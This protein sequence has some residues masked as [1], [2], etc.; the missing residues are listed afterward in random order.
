VNDSSASKNNELQSC[1][2]RRVDFWVRVPVIGNSNVY[3]TSSYRNSTSSTPSSYRQLELEK[4]TRRL[5]TLRIA[6][7]LYRFIHIRWGEPNCIHHRTAPDVDAFT[8]QMW[9][10]TL[11]CIV[12]PCENEFQNVSQLELSHHGGYWAV[13]VQYWC[14]A[15]RMY[16]QASEG[17]EKWDGWEHSDSTP[18]SYNF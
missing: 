8:L 4:S 12:A 2:L 7:Q 16:P 15:Q 1:K 18:E 13:C 17:N 11:H 6:S 3:W 10:Y 9:C 14:V 5:W